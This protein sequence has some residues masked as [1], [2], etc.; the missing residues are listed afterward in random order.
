MMVLLTALSIVDSSLV[1]FSNLF[2]S[3]QFQVFVQAFAQ[4][5]KQAAARE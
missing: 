4:A 2:V 1:S 3:L 5:Y